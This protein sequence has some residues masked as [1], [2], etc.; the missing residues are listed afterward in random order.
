VAGGGVAGGGVGGGGVVRGR[1][2]AGV[3]R[4]GVSIASIMP[5]CAEVRNMHGVLHTKA[6]IRGAPGPC[7]VP[8]RSGRRRPTSSHAAR[9]SCRRERRGV[10]SCGLSRSTRPTIV[11]WKRLTHSTRL[12]ESASERR[13]ERDLNPRGLASQSFSR[14]SPVVARVG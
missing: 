13:R 7:R 8:G 4:A 9:G 12:I 11:I 5:W 2:Q 1:R 10:S 14:P 6:G 3:A